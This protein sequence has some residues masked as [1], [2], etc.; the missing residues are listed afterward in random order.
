MLSPCESHHHSV[1]T[2]WKGRTYCVWWKP[3]MSH[4]AFMD[5]GECP[6]YWLI[7]LEQSS[8]MVGVIAGRILI[9]HPS[10]SWC[11]PPHPPSPGKEMCEACPLKSLTN[12]VWI[13]RVGIFCKKE[14]GGLTSDVVLDGAAFRSSCG[15]VSFVVQSVLV[16]CDFLEISVQNY[17]SGPCIFLRSVI[18]PYPR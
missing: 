2:S 16:A 11:M 4:K 5:T 8:Y 18:Y 14:H 9:P 10:F 1:L 6:V 12:F 13:L 7:G 15:L 3:G 17:I